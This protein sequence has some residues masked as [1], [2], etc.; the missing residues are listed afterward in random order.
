M[1]ISFISLYCTGIFALITRQCACDYQEEDSGKQ[2]FTAR[3]SYAS[4]VLGVVIL[5]VRL[6]VTRVLC[7]TPF[8]RYNRL[9]NR[10]DNRLDRVERT[11]SHALFV[12]PVVKPGCTTGLTTRL[13][14]R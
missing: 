1:L 11:N 4:T 10:F 12:Q 3:R 9:P 13:Y 7:D 6:S 2:V 8:T 5:S 14:T